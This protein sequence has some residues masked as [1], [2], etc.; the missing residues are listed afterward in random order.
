MFNVSAL[1]LTTPIPRTSV[2][3]FSIHAPQVEILDPRLLGGSVPV[4]IIFNLHPAYYHYST[5]TTAAAAAADFCFT[6]CS[7][8]MHVYKKV[9]QTDPLAE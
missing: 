8:C 6:F 7:Y 9:S 1:L 5:T 2:L 4:V 3:R